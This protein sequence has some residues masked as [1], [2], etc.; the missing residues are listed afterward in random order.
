MSTRR[1]RLERKLEKRQEWAEGRESNATAIH[2]RDEHLRGDWAFITQPGHIPERA[3]MNRR[4]DKA[5]EHSNMAQH[6]RD[7]A[8]GLNRQLN[9]T[10]FS[11]DH[12]AIEALE[13]KI[14]VLTAKQERNKALNKLIRKGDRAGIAALGIKSEALIDELFKPD[15]GGR[16]GIP[17]YE[18]TNNNANI[19]RLKK[20]I[21]EIKR[22]QG[23]TKAAEDNGGT[24]ILRAREVE[25]QRTYCRVVFAEKPERDII[26]SLKAAQ[27]HWDGASWV[28]FVD[29]IPEGVPA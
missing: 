3:R 14:E 25:G 2:K 5:F 28:G 9:N 1:E 24:T 27:F 8:D 13:E 19:R 7:K 15:Y 23:L 26:D 18:L 20:R 29:S 17:S 16:V 11:D 10:I 4:A 12:D 6:H 22:R 21:E